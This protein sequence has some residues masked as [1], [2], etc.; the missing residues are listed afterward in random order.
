MKVEKN[1]NEYTENKNKNKKIRAKS[2]GQ[3]PA[4]IPS[5]WCWME[6]NGTFVVS[7]KED[8]RADFFLLEML[9]TKSI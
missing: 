6:S 1:T 5:I 9:S 8:I 4:A 7:N 3:I 2:K